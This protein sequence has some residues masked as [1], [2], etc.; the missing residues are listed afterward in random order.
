MLSNAI[1]SRTWMALTLCIWYRIWWSQPKKKVVLGNRRGATV[2]RPSPWLVMQQFQK[3]RYLSNEE[4]E[5]PWSMTCLRCN[6]V[7]YTPDGKNVLCILKQQ[8]IEHLL[9]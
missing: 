1:P 8:E 6:N 7:N 3:D 5:N 9:G 2:V 4:M